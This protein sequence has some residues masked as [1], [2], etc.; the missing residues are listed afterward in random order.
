[1]RESV[2]ETGAECLVIALEEAVEGV[3]KC[4]E[5]ISVHNGL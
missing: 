5:G 4:L 3:W 2:S 1:M